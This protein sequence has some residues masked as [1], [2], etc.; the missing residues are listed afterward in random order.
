MA[1]LIGALC[2]AKRQEET[3][4]AYYTEVSEQYETQKAEDKAALDAVLEAEAER[5]AAL[6][7]ID[8]FYQKLHDGFDVNILVIGDSIGAGSGGTAGNRWYELLESGIE[9]TYEVNAHITNISMGGNTSYAG[10]VRTMALD[11]G[12]DYDLAILCYGQNDSVIDFDLYY[13]SI[14]R[15][16]SSKYADCN[17]IA[18]LESSQKEYT[19]KMVVVQE[20]CEYYGIPVADT[21]AAYSEYNYDDLVTDGVHPND[22]GY[23]LYYREVMNAI[24]ENYDEDAVFNIRDMEPLNSRAY[25]FDTFRF[26]SAEEFDRNEFTFEITAD[27]IGMDVVNAVLGIDYSFQSGEH[28]TEIYVDGALYAAPTVNFDYDFSQRHI[29]IVDQDI[30]VRDSIKVV[31]DSEEGADS[32]QGLIFHGMKS[33]E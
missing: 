21:I 16:V 26:V 32:F 15:A 13:E 4:T 29:M 17:M 8:T 6:E 27:V 2:Y 31:F 24:V 22:E 18:I 7:A 5:L 3:L 1:A 12:I 14:I 28:V 11:D 25:D 9:E 30:T 19:E 10:Y 33:G 23:R 20:I